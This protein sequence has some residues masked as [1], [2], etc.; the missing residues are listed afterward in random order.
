MQGL[1]FVVSG[2]GFGRGRGLGLDSWVFLLAYGCHEALNLL[3][4]VQPSS[5]EP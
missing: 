3:S 5:L 4:G 2:S 1:G